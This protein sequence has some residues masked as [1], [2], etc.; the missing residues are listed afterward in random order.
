M[1]KRLLRS[2]CVICVICAICGSQT[3]GAQTPSGAR[4][5]VP[6]EWRVW[7]ADHWSSRYSP[8]DQ[9][10]AQN[11]NNLKMAWQWKAESFGAD[12]AALKGLSELAPAL[13]E[14]IANNRPTVIEVPMERLPSPF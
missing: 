4:G 6:G 12:G 5:N 9:I 7:G 8:L 3:V 14:A 1:M 10:N 11:F 2:I 13:R